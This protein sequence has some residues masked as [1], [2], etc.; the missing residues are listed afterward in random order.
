MWL[1][2][3][4]V[5]GFF[6]DGSLLLNKWPTDMEAYRP[7]TFLLYDTYLR[8]H[9]SGRLDTLAV[10]P[11]GV[12]IGIQRL[13]STPQT[14]GPRATFHFADDLFYWNLREQFE[15]TVFDRN[16]N[17]QR[18]IRREWDPVPVTSDDIRRAEGNEISLLEQEMV[19]PSHHLPHGRIY[20]DLMGN[21]WVERWPFED[22]RTHPVYPPVRFSSV[23][24]DV[25]DPSGVWLGQVTTPPHYRVDEIG[26]DYVAGVWVDEHDVEFV[27]IYDL[28]KDPGGASR[29]GLGDRQ[30][31]VR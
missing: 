26:S 21:V 7:G 24:W 15:I 11:D 31:M 2:R 30:R 5:E 14:F 18:K 28:V 4:S 9:P 22:D 27:R 25:F 13:F 20:V 29:T 16:G 8:A 19:Y 3:T 10:L 12:W 6:S 23:E 1:P 17:V